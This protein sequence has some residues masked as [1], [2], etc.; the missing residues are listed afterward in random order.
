MIPHY[1]AGAAA[2]L[3]L[4]WLLRTP[5]EQHSLRSE[6]RRWLAAGKPA[7]PPHLAKAE[8]LRN[9]AARFGT[10]VLIETGTFTGLMVRAMRTD[11]EE[12]HSVE[13]SETLAGHAALRF[14]R[15]PHIHIHQ[16][17]STQILPDLLRALDRP[18]LFWLDGHYSGGVTA[19][20][21][22]VTPIM[23][24]LGCITS[25]PVRGHVILIDDARLFVGA[26]DYPTLAE[27]EGLV[28]RQRPELRVS[29]ADDV[30][31]IAPAPADQR[32]RGS[33]AR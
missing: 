23:D 12:I 9:A 3:R 6:Y 7:P 30:I 20:G 28:A 25:H 19:R 29:V 10:T 4:K 33:A 22:K 16:G 8:V 1:S 21:S 27:V 11:F 26:D 15:Y 24:E 5:L 32:P 31:R 14:A 13:L 2:W 17:D 18:A